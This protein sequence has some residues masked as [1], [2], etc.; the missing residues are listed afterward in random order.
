MFRYY[1]EKLHVNH[2]WEVKGSVLL[3]FCP[4]WQSLSLLHWHEAISFDSHPTVDGMWVTT[5]YILSEINFIMYPQQFARTHIFSRVNRVTMRVGCHAQEH[6]IITQSKCNCRSVHSEGYKQS[7]AP[8]LNRE[9]TNNG[10]A[11]HLFIHVIPY[12][13]RSYLI[14]SGRQTV[15]LG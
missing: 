6:N 11:T 7:P 4:Y 15:R 8:L 10:S 14:K 3:A 9:I 1:R 12:K 13:N 5:G 2:F